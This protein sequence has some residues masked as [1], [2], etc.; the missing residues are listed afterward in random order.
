MTE[1]EWIKNCDIAKAKI[2]SLQEELDC[3][4]ALLYEYQMTWTSAG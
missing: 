3:W 4:Q 1:A 2:E